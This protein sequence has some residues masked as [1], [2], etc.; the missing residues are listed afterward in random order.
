MLSFIESSPIESRYF[1]C[2]GCF[3]M[4]NCIVRY[5][6]DI[7]QAISQ[8]STQILTSRTL[9]S[10]AIADVPIFVEVQNSSCCPKGHPFLAVSSH[11]LAVN[12]W[13]EME[14]HV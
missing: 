8:T 1:D 3:L 6:L 10:S 5:R 12:H 11:G 13:H 2:F 4:L 14:T 9:S 7:L